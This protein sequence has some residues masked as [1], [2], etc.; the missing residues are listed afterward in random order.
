MKYSFTKDNNLIEI[1]LTPESYTAWYQ[2]NAAMNAVIKDLVDQN[3]KEL[4]EK[5]QWPPSLE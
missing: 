1:D 3:K 4:T 2:Q 5:G